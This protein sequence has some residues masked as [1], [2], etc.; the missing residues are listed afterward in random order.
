MIQREEV[1][2]DIN[3]FCMENVFNG[4]QKY[5]T[6]GNSPL[7]IVV[8]LG[9]QS[10]CKL[11]EQMKGAFDSLLNIRPEIR[12]IYITTDDFLSDSSFKHDLT[13]IFEQFNEQGILVAGRMLN[14][15]MSFV[16]KM[17]D[18]IL[19]DQCALDGIKKLKEQL[20]SI[21]NLNFVQFSN[22]SFFGV[23]DQKLGKNE[24][25]YSKA[26][27]F[28]NTGSE[29]KC[30]L[31]STVYH[32]Q[33]SIFENSYESAARTIAMQILR[34]AIFQNRRSSDKADDPDDYCWYYLGME[35]MKLP[36]LLICNILITTYAAQLNN[37]SLHEQERKLFKERLEQVLLGEIRSSCD[38]FKK[39]EWIRYLPMNVQ[40]NVEPERRGIFGTRSRN[41]YSAI[42]YSQMLVDK[43][44]L[45]V[46]LTEYT[47]DKVLELQTDDCLIEVI[48]DALRVLNRT[49][50][51]VPR[52]RMTIID[53]IK[54]LTRNLEKRINSIDL[55]GST[56]SEESYFQQLFD[57]YTR[58]EILEIAIR[59]LKLCVGNEPLEKK[60]DTLIDSMN[61]N[62][63]NSKKILEE[64]RINS[65]GGTNI[66]ELP[67]F[68]HN[69][70]IPV[71][72]PVR[73]AC[74][75]I[76]QSILDKLVND[77]TIL[78]KNA[79]SFFS[80]VKESSM[81]KNSIGHVSG[82]KLMSPL[83]FEVF[84]EKPMAVQ[85]MRVKV[86]TRFRANTMQVLSYCEWS[87][88][89]N[90]FAYYRGE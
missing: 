48:S 47:E 73:E 51:A 64:L 17:D 49:D 72:I 19:A 3:D 39:S 50:T 15:E 43:E 7:A 52:M 75:Y 60:L 24:C 18:S 16:A 69:L 32:L 84:V 54:E 40:H 55:E 5:T 45:D 41:S 59:V 56:E 12:F 88:T 83:N 38:I 29:N 70:Q 31:W 74:G 77:E 46:I 82:D 57:R 28:I 53:T 85:D 33:K 65:Y 34:D 1:R 22:I 9:E 62:C 10:V 61:T 30:G 13:D 87:S 35:E 26:F 66:L 21:R 71:S 90:L 2:N 25:D 8:F 86:D 58:K 68:V 63:A 6:F 11:E 20:D 78:R 67:D 23:F 27:R 79:E 80:R 14:I 89:K 36:E 4:T 42:D 81:N 76:D 44:M 37:V